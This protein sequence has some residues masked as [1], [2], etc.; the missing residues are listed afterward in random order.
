MVSEIAYCAKV[1]AAKPDKLNSSSRTQIVVPD[2][3]CTI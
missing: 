3:K 2:T 1:H